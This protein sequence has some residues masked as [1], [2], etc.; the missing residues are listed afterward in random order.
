ESAFAR[1]ACFGVTDFACE[2][3]SLACRDDFACEVSSLACRDE[4]RPK[5]ERSLAE[6]P[7]SRTEPPR[8]SGEQPILKTG[9]AT[10]PRS[11]P[12]QIVD[13]EVRSPVDRRLY[14]IDICR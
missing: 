3:S 13:C 6:A 4:A 2:V 8:V 14:Q 9:R 1:G 10:G 5:G 11:L 7:R 12:P